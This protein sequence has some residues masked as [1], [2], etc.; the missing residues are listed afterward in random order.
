MVPL[1]NPKEKNN[2]CVEKK[3]TDD[4]CTWGKQ[5]H[6]GFKRWNDIPE[7]KTQTIVKTQK[8]NQ[9]RINF[10]FIAFLVYN[11]FT[12]KF[13]FD[14]QNLYIINQCIQFDA[15]GAKYTAMKP[16]P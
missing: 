9:K 7:L 10:V 14:M 6:S 4:Y 8:N 13:F 3:I 15:F 11:L 2:C 5:S 1:K 16:A 12:C